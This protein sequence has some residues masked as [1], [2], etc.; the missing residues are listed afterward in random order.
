MEQTFEMRFEEFLLKIHFFLP[1]PM[2]FEQSIECFY[3]P[4]KSSPQQLKQARQNLEAVTSHPEN[5]VNLFL[6]KL[7][8]ASDPDVQ[9]FILER[10]NFLYTH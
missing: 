2:N 10:I 7:P 3:H 6:S 5:F 9:F 4:D 1:C 8:S